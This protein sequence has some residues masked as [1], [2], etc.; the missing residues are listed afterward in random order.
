MRS[1]A[2]RLA[3]SLL[4]ASGAAACGPAVHTAPTTPPAPARPLATAL[5]ARPDATNLLPP[6]VAFQRGLMPLEATGIPA[7]LQAHP[8]WDGRGVLI[9]ILDSGIDPGVDGL[10]TTTTGEPKIADLRDFSGEGRVALAPVT[11]LGDSVTVGGRTVAGMG[12][13][14]G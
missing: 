10:Q 8:E 3:V 4:A 7:F 13:L 1:L 12:R 9:A 2:R 5:A 14:R 11:P 6:V